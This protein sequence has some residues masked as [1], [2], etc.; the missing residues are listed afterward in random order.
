MEAIA[1]HIDGIYLI[2]GNKHKHSPIQ[3]WEAVIREEER[4]SPISDYHE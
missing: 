3:E 2:D 4:N 1:T